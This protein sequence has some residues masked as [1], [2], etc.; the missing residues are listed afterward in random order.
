M[1]HFLFPEAA[2]ASITQNLVKFP[3]TPV[4]DLLQRFLPPLE[5][6]FGDTVENVCKALENSKTKDSRSKTNVPSLHLAERS[7]TTEPVKL[8]QT[9]LDNS[10]SVLP[11]TSTG[12]FYSTT[13]RE[14]ILATICQEHTSRRA[15]LLSG[16]PGN[17]NQ[18][19]TQHPV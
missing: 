5:G 10:T 3:E 18:N 4:F 11:S 16:K 9:S 14:R 13:E 2:L 7:S 1:R 19:P 15:V 12:S 8:V 17:K 6:N